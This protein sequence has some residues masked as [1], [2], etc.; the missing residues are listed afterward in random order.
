MTDSES[1]LQTIDNLTIT[2]DDGRSDDFEEEMARFASVVANIRLDR[3]PD[4][5]VSIYMK[6]QKS[7]AELEADVPE[8]NA[9]VS[10]CKV[11][12]LF[13]HG[14]ASLVVCFV[15]YIMRTDS[16]MAINRLYTAM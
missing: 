9:S 3:L 4:F 10:S 13:N 7:R 2:E 5:A 12:E 15:A 6:Q 16:K 14:K 8:T 1:A 11:I